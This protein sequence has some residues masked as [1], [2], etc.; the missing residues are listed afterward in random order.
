MAPKLIYIGVFITVLLLIYQLTTYHQAWRLLYDSSLPDTHRPNLAITGRTNIWADLS[1]EESLSVE[2]FLHASSAA[3]D[4][5][6]VRS[7]SS[8]EVDSILVVELLRPNKTD[9]LQYLDGEDE[10]LKVTPLRFARVAVR[11]NLGERPR[12]EEYT[13]GPLPVSHLTYIHALSFPYNSGRSW[14]EMPT[15]DAS[16]VIKWMDS[17]GEQVADIVNDIFGPPTQGFRSSE[18]SNV[19][20]EASSNDR[21]F[22]EGNRTMRWIGFFQKSNASTLLAQGLYFK[23]DTTGPDPKEWQVVCWFYNNTIYPTTQALRTAWASPGFQKLPG[24][25]DGAWTKL[26]ADGNPDP[27]AY[28]TSQPPIFHQVG[29]SRVQIDREQSFVSWMGI[30]FNF[31]FSQVNGIALYDI[32]LDGER[33]VY[34]LSLQEA[35]AHYA[36]SDPMQSGTAF[37]DSVFG[38]GSRLSELVPGFDCPSYAH[39]VDT[40]YCRSG[41]RYSRSNTVCIFEAPTDYPLQR[42]SRGRTITAF[43]NSVL[44]L[45]TVAVI[46]NYDYL[47]EYIFYLDGT[48]EALVA[49]YQGAYWPNGTHPEYGYRIHDA[50]SSSIHDHVL[51]FK[52]DL[53][54]G[55]TTKNSMSVLTVAEQQTPYPWSNG[56]IINTMHLERSQ[57][58][59]ENHSSINWPPNSASMYVVTGPKN[60]FGEHR[61]YRIVPGTGVGTPIHLTIKNSTNLEKAAEW[62]TS[63]FFITKQKDTEP[64][65]ASPANALSPSDPLIRFSRFLNGETSLMKILIWFNLGSHHIPHTGDL[66]N[67][68]MT[69]SATSIMF[70][71]HNYHLHDRARALTPGIRVEAIREADGADQLDIKYLGQPGTRPDLTGFNIGSAQPER[72][73]PLEDKILSL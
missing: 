40:S 56:Q 55:G 45:R 70:R 18:S 47:I 35:I 54:I 67:T 71:P 46:G 66:P 10:G 62:A 12:I 22:Y 4:P 11:R 24:N 68:L 8:R 17:I 64:R 38:M 72:K 20:F 32:R 15:P 23:A 21:V 28:P 51:N 29:E 16:A 5:N 39:F 31:A 7:T 6:F 58:T 19:V 27:D 69:T 30:G 44:I 73:F 2:S 43:S 3:L 52:A 57:V 48:F 25:R 59:N 14:S 63:D 50:F 53:D 61:G 41:T 26:E 37:L 9:A 49:T 33:I 65:S 34:E 42:H 1:N 36:G 13:I 60:D